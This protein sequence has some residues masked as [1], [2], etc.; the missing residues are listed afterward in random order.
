VTLNCCGR[1]LCSKKSRQNN[2]WVCHGVLQAN[3]TWQYLTHHLRYTQR[4][5]NTS[6]AD[7]AAPSIDSETR[8]TPRRSAGRI[9][10][11]QPLHTIHYVHK[12]SRSGRK[13]WYV[14][15]HMPPSNYYYVILM[16]PSMIFENQ[17]MPALLYPA[18]PISMTFA[19]HERK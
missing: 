18:R 1:C 3:R 4:N 2:L 6:R 19:R 9:C 16:Y 11:S 12:T 17:T 15:L 8:R 10:R 13:I 14:H 5:L 7:C